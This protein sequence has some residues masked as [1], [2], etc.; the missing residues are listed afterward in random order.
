MKFLVITDLHEKKSALE[1]INALCG[2]YSVDAVLF[3]GDVVELGTGTEE[4]LEIL[5]QFESEVYFIP[6][7]CDPLDLP[8]KASSCVHSMHGK[9]F[10]IG[11]TYFAALGGSNPTIFNTPFELQEDDI[12]EKLESISKENMVLMTHAPAH[13]TKLDKITIG[14]H[15]GSKAISDII[16]KYKP[17]VALSGHIHEA[18]AIVEKDGTLY[19]NPGAAKE[20]HAALLTI[21]NGK[22]TA[23]RV[24]PAD[25]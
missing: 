25:A 4:A 5:K 22:A 11:G 1:W 8:E 16:A 7:N 15:V 18:I 23:V 14:L 17:I 20:G 3:L 24:G 21:E 9:G 12:K 10:E 19:V 2:K 6:G 13:G